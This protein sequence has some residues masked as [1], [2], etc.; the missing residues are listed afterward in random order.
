MGQVLGS[1]KKEETKE[2]GNWGKRKPRKEA[3]PAELTL[4]PM[5]VV[6][7]VA[8]RLKRHSAHTNM[9]AAMGHPRP[10]KF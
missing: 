8:T 10:R 9:A 6:I 7:V 3:T 2:R 5:S 4:S 1:T